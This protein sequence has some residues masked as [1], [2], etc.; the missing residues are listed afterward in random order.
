MLMERGCTV[1]SKG[2][3]GYTALH[4]VAYTPFVKLCEFLLAN[5]ANMDA[6][7]RNGSTPLLIAAREGHASVV[8]TL[9]A[10]RADPNDGGDKGLTPLLMASAE[11]HLDTVRLLLLY[12]AD[13]TESLFEGRTPLHE[14]A[15][16]GHTDVCLELIR[17]GHASILAADKEGI[18]PLMIAAKHQG[19]GQLMTDLVPKTPH[20]GKLKAE[21][22]RLPPAAALAN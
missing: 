17:E 4:Q 7:S 19:L 12:K 13:A 5:G 9:L 3:F 14:A 15:E 10:H 2:A 16:A 18:T 21:V 22:S 20:S 6:L 8:A 1:S 11:G